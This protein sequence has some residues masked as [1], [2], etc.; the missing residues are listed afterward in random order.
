M[1]FLQFTNE[2]LED[3]IPHRGI[4]APVGFS[5]SWRSYPPT[6]LTSKL[7]GEGQA[8]VGE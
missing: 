7:L 4:G 6:K 5:K 3:T 1:V 8:H 2:R